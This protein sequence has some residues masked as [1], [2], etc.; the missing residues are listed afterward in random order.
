[1]KLSI[2]WADRE[3]PILVCDE[4]NNDIAEFFHA[5]QATVEQTY[6]EA[7]RLAKFLVEANNANSQQ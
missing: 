7:L 2:A 5:E 6:D 1:M 3:H 4:D